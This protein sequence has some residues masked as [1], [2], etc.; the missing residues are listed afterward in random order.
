MESVLENELARIE[1]LIEDQVESMDSTEEPEATKDEL[2]NI[3]NSTF[4]FTKKFQTL[5]DL[6][7]KLVL[8]SETVI[9]MNE[10]NQSR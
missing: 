3:D 5:L 2:W 6:S 7:S 8:V 10:K 9:R 1:D 4:R